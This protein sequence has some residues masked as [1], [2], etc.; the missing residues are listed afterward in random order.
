[1]Y[2]QYPRPEKQNKNEHS[3]ASSLPDFLDAGQLLRKMSGNYGGNILDASP[4]IPL[5]M[6]KLHSM[7]SRKARGQ[8]FTARSF[9]EH[10]A[11][12]PVVPMSQKRYQNEA[13][14][15]SA[16]LGEPRYHHNDQRRDFRDPR[17][18]NSEPTE[19]SEAQRQK[20]QQKFIK[21]FDRDSMKSFRNQHNKSDLLRLQ[22]QFSKYY[23]GD[24]KQAQQTLQRLIN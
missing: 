5:S 18:L 6:D 3:I 22:Q 23:A 14:D 21:E 13:R 10:E 11:S 1:M 2:D 20:A 8:D 24:D 17:S 7:D 16:S 9:Q 12:S 4:A 15:M 19:N